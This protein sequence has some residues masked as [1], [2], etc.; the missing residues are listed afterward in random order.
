MVEPST[1]YIDESHEF[2]ST[3][4]YFAHSDGLDSK[5][6]KRRYKNMLEDTTI[7]INMVVNYFLLL[8]INII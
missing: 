5:S 1:M 8:M 4:K 6:N 7:I 2:L 3:F